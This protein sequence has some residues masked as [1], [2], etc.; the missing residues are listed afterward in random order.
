MKEWSIL[1]D[2]VKCITHDEL[3]AFQ[4]LNIDTLNY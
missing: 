3:E 1:I 2:H 4:K